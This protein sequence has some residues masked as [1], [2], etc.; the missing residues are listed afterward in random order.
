MKILVTGASGFIG[1]AVWQAAARQGHEVLATGRRPLAAPGYVPGD[2]TAGCDF[3]FAPDVVLHAAARSSPWGTRREFERQNVEATRHV[4]DFCERHG[5]PHLVHLSTTAVMYDQS[6]QFGLTEASPLPPHPINT[7]AETKRE[8]ERVVQAY[9]GS[10]CIV[11]PRAV[12]GPGDTV[13]FPRILR[14]AAAGRLPL[15]ESDQPVW[16]DLIYIETLVAYL[17]RIVETRAS[18]LY[19]LTNNQPVPILEFLG[20]VF[21]RLHLP[22]P[23][24]KVPVG[25]AMAFATAI[26]AVYGALPFLGEPPLTR[27]G[28]SVFAYSKTFDVSKALHDLGPPAVGLDEGVDRF[29][30]HWQ[31]TSSR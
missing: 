23:R 12:F 10:W 24:R 14:A 20:T 15:I 17:L 19:V 21:A 8:A 9:R 3:E 13:V 16:G 26:E 25:R 31:Q 11:R 29:V 28:V 7:Y 6:H 4:V 22:A 18:G 30:R 2:L 5:R 1:G 27:F